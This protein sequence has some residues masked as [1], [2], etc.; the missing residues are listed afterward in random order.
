MHPSAIKRSEKMRIESGR[1][2]ESERISRTNEFKKGIRTLNK[3]TS[4]PIKIPVTTLSAISFMS[5]RVL[6]FINKTKAKFY[7]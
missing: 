3:L 7:F 2:F 4:S 6:L 1:S 5:S